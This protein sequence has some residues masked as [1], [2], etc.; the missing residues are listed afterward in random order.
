MN[1][2]AQT[3]SP[4][5]HVNSRYWPITGWSKP[6]R[7]LN[8]CWSGSGAIV[9]PAGMMGL[10]VAG[11]MPAARR[12]V[13]WSTLLISSSRMRRPIDGPAAVGLKPG[14]DRTR[15]VLGQPMVPG[16]GGGADAG[17]ENALRRDR[18]QIQ[19]AVREEP[20]LYF[21]AFQL[22]GPGK[23]RK[24]LRV[25]VKGVDLRLAGAHR[26]IGGSV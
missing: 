18:V 4:V 12:A 25:L 19:D 3:S 10:P 5:R 23:R 22:K 20:F 26:E 1:S 14:Q 16:V 9:A 15:I 2:M 13:S 11:S 8:S 7:R 21:H 17:P 24:P 6:S